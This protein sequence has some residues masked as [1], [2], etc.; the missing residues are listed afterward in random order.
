[1]KT[2]LKIT[3]FLAELSKEIGYKISN[4]PNYFKQKKD[5]EPDKIWKEVKNDLPLKESLRKKG[6]WLYSLR[7]VARFL[8]VPEGEI[9]AFMYKKQLEPS[10]IADYE[11]KMIITYFHTQLI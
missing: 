3:S 5:M 6:Y 4:L 8:K 10:W 2:W 11:L 1:M 9:R 7:K